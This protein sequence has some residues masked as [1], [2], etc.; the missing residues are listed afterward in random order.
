LLTAVRAVEITTL[1]K[2]ED[3]KTVYHVL[4]V[5]EI[6]EVRISGESGLN[7]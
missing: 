3:G 1:S 2:D 7:P 5:P 4:T 6:Q